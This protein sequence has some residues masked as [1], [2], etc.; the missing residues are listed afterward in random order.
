[1]LVHSQVYDELITIKESI[2]EFE[3]YF[4]EEVVAMKIYIS[5]DYDKDVARSIEEYFFNFVSTMMG[6]LIICK[7]VCNEHSQL[8]YEFLSKDDFENFKE[9]TDWLN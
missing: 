5:N 8:P 2:L 7:T 4:G 6:R 3:K 9:T 1:M